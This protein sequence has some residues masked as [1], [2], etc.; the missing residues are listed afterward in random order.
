MGEFPSIYLAL[1]I[2][3][4]VTF[5]NSIPQLD[6]VVIDLGVRI[7]LVPEYSAFEVSYA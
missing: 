2:L 6:L 4:G 3:E 1:G 7:I 5:M